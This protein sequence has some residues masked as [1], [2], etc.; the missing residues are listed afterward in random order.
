MDRSGLDEMQQSKR[1][2]IGNQCFLLLLYLLL[3][4]G[5]LYGFGFRWVE[6]PANIMILLTLCSG[7]YVVRLIAA[8]AYVGPNKGKD[9]TAVRTIMTSAAAVLTGLVVVYLLKSVDL[10]SKAGI[11]EIAAPVLFITAAVAITVAVTVGVLN[12]I[13]TRRED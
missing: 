9:R 7:I 6:Y 11:D 1:N 12:R 2:K 10:V 13:Q 3:I 4:D 8:N 5:G